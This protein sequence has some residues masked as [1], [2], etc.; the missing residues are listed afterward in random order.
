MNLSCSV[1]TDS[2]ISTMS[3]EYPNSVAQWS[4]NEAHG[5]LYG[6]YMNKDGVPGCFQIQGFTIWRSF[7]FGIYVQV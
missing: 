2:I 3:K 5:G 4:E 6:L 1:F 7:D